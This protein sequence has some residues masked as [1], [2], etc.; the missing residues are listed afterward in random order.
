MKK[1]LLF[2]VAFG[3]CIFV[4]AQQVKVGADNS[5][6]QSVNGFQTFGWSS[7]I[8]QIP[9]ANLFI[10]PNGDYVFNNEST[11]NRIKKAIKFELNAK[12]FKETDNNPDMLV[13]FRITENPG[14]LHTF[15]GYK[16]YNEGLDS[17]RTPTNIETVK[18]KPGTLLINIVDAKSGK[19]AWQG[20]ASGILKPSMVNSDVK[21]RE[22][23]AA[24]FSDFHFHAKK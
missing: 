23:V 22:A 16:M 8:N 19:V 20:Y 14:T 9:K 12:G 5:F 11:R 18:V 17:T 7:E 21:V 1:L 10:T 6:K 13:L 2:A 15:N 3:C 4:S 24:I